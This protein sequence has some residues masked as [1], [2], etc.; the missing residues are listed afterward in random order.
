M[1]TFFCLNI[2]CVTDKHAS[3]NAIVKNFFKNVVKKYYF[4]GM[5]VTVSYTRIGNPDCR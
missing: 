1:L 3:A 5:I 4:I 2:F